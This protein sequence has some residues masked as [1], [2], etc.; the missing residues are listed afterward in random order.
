MRDLKSMDYFY[1]STAVTAVAGG[2][3]FFG[4]TVHLF[5]PSCSCEHSIQG[6]M[7]HIVQFRGYTKFLDGQSSKVEVAV[8]SH[9]A[10]MFPT[11]V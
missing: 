3:M 7:Q 8:S 6:N 2:I 5:R 11:P 9:L 1:A 10:T 4:L